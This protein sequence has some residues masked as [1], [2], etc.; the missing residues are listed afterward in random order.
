MSMADDF[1]PATGFRIDGEVAAVTGGASGI[2]LAAARAMARAGGRVHLLDRNAEAAAAAARAIAADGG[3]A[4]SHVADVTDEA[5][6]EAAFAAIIKAEGRLDILVNSAGLAIRKPAVELALAD[7]QK[8]VDVNLTGTFLASRA[9]ARHMIPKKKGA[10]VNLASIM[11]L[12]GGGLY[13]NISYQSTK[14][15]IVNLTR[16]LAIEWAGVGIRVNALAPTW[17]KTEF[18][19]PLLDNPELVARMEAMTPLGRIAETSEVA[20]AILF[21]VSPAAA[22]VTGTT[23]PVD[24]GFLAQ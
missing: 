18:V 19:R 22:M 3:V 20:G 24:G 17:V 15:A 14:G 16:A 11:G 23:L 1:D 9:A 2:G 8:V 5:S 6:V 13:P 12:S 21:L 10:I 4:A 7:W